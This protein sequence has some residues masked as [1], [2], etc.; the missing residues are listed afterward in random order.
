METSED[1]IRI[2]NKRIEMILYKKMNY[3]FKSK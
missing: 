2:I 1:G 3:N